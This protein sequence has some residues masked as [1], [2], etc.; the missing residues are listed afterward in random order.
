MDTAFISDRKC[1]VIPRTKLLTV[2]WYPSVCPIRKR[3]N[4]YFKIQSAQSNSRIRSRN[5]SLFYCSFSKQIQRHKKKVPTYRA[6]HIYL[7]KI[8]R[9]KERNG[10]NIQNSCC[11]PASENNLWDQKKKHDLPTDC[12]YHILRPPPRAKFLNE[13][14][15]SSIFS[16]SS[17]AQCS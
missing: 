13:Y 7:V 11:C 10:Y 16:S 2:W 17:H 3:Q 8:A 15:E 12:H 4:N 1:T 5:Y 14:V 6:S 9:I